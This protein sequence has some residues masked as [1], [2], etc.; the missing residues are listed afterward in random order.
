M[1]IVSR[2]EPSPP[3]E[4]LTRVVSHGIR[5]KP[6]E[7]E[8]DITFPAFTTSGPHTDAFQEATT[9]GLVDAEEVESPLTRASSRTRVG[10]DRE[11]GGDFKLVTWVE[12]DPEV[13][14]PR[15]CDEALLIRPR[16][17][18]PRNMSKAAKWCVCFEDSGMSKGRSSST[19]QAQHPARHPPVLRFR[20]RQQHNHRRI[21]SRRR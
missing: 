19:L 15:R 18:N 11:K 1:R 20:L 17:Q 9:T 7:P 3:T 10:S 12:N 2:K 16:H 13:R 6:I 21:G 4:S 5:Q 14:L 8:D